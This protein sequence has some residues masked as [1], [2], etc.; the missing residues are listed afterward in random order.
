MNESNISN[1]NMTIYEKEQKIQDKL[2]E[3][4]IYITQNNLNN[5]SELL[6]NEEKKIKEK[7]KELNGVLT[8]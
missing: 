2:K 8:I 5:A 3:E 1:N 6:S 4:L 7:T